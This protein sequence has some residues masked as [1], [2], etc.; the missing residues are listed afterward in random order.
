MALTLINRAGRTVGFTGTI[1]SKNPSFLDSGSWKGQYSSRITVPAGT[2]L[3]NA[4]LE[5]DGVFRTYVEGRGEIITNENSTSRVLQFDTPT[6]IY[7]E[8]ANWTLEKDRKMLVT[9]TEAPPLRN[10]VLARLGVAL[11]A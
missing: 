10:C 1:N 6:D 2:W 5:G 11:W 4:T 3:L 7:F 8:V 9:L